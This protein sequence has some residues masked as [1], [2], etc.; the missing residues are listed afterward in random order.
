MR[1]RQRE[2]LNRIN[3]DFTRDNE[4]EEIYIVKTIDRIKR[5]IEAYGNKYGVKGFVLGLSGGVDS[6]VC[7][8][9]VADAGLLFN[10][11]L[12]LLLLPCGDQKDIS[13][14]IECADALTAQFDNI[15]HEIMPITPSF[16]GVEEV[17]ENS[18]FAEDFD[19]YA[20]GNTQARLRM[21]HQYALSKRR[22]VIGTDHATENVVGYYTKYGDGG[23]DFNPMDGLL[24]PDIYEIAKRYHAPK[25]VLEKK[26][27]AGLG[28]SENDEAEL[29]LTY[30]EIADYLKGIPLEREK[31][32]RISSLF[33]K[34]EHK[35]NQIASPFTPWWQGKEEETSHIVVDMIHT[36]IDGAMACENA[37]AAV[38]QAACFIDENPKM[39]VLYVRDYHPLNHISFT[40]QGGEWPQH[41]MQ[42]TE[43]VQ[44]PANFYAT[45][46][47]VNTPI[48]RYNVFNKGMDAGKEEYSGFNA[49]N[50]VFGPLKYNITRN[51]VVSGIATEYCVKNTVLDLV[52]NGFQVSVLKDAL[53]YINEET[54]LETLRE[55]EGLGV[56]LI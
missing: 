31:M 49:T 3:L 13:D 42:E 52:K 45:Q 9:L 36:F 55:L 19:V 46:K 20:K 28:I 25:A 35:R 23:A 18:M 24:K 32:M 14:A 4:T 2:I 34:S 10:A 26:P 54:H 50:D 43:E 12:H 56:K 37:Q 48:I 15:T 8:A 41:A 38:E 53:G 51:V 1:M 33:E 16:A 11:T 47:T 29:G 6:Y 27:A 39:R 30:A 22:L 7:A 40:E 17:L 5:A 21:V 44:F